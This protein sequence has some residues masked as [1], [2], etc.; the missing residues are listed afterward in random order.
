MKDWK[1]KVLKEEKTMKKTTMKKRTMILLIAGLLVGALAG[2][3]FAFSGTDEADVTIDDGMLNDNLSGTPEN[4]ENEADAN[5][6][7]TAGDADQVFIDD[8]DVTD[9]GDNAMIAHYFSITGT[10][11][12]IEEENDTIRVTIEDE[13]GNPAVL[14]LSENTVYPFSDEPSVGDAVTGWYLTEA[15]MIAIWPAEY[16]I[17]VLVAG[18]PE[19]GNLKVDR[20]NT[21]A[22]NEEGYMLSQDGTFAF[23]IDENTQV[24][25]ANGD[26][27]TGGDIEGRRIVV[28][29][30]ISTRSIPEFA[31]ASRLIVLYEDA[32]TLPIEI[33]VD[34]ES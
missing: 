19:G 33:D 12:S 13:Y 20:F 16:N 29:Y 30:D 14:V 11:V 32:V 5:E 23:R 24:I 6:A 28:I 18:A 26:D 9:N 21:W 4:D 34:F 3:A 22:D 15:P 1:R 31:T 10:I 8:W 27:F 17:S 25:L 7:D 2:I